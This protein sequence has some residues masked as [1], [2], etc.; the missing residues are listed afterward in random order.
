L[1]AAEAGEVINDCEAR[2][3]AAV[4]IATHIYVAPAAASDAPAPVPGGGR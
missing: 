4:P 2:I 3:R 1:S